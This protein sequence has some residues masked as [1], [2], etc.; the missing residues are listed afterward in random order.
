MTN[1]HLSTQGVKPHFS[2]PV[3]KAS[4]MVFASSRRYLG[5]Y[6]YLWAIIKNPAQHETALCSKK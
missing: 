3:Q 5:G 2:P 6:K 1:E 4:F